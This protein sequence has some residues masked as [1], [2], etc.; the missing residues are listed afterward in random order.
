[1]K[2]LVANAG[3][4]SLKCQFL[5]MPSE[6]QLA[7]AKVERLGT[8]RAVIGSTDRTGQ[9]RE[10]TTPLLCY[11]EAIEFVLGVLT[12]PAKGALSSIS[13]IDA[14]AFKPVYAK[15]ISGCQ[16]MDRRVLDA[17]AEYCD[18]VAPLHNPAYIEAIES[19]A[20]VLPGTPLVGLFEDF[21][22]DNV[23]DYV[24][25]YPIPWEWTEKYGIRKRFFHGASHCY[26]SNRVAELMGQKLDDLNVI[27]AHLGGS[28]S[29]QCIQHGRGIEG[30][31][32]FTLQNGVPQSVRPGEIDPFMIAYLV[33]EGEGTVEEIVDRLM[34]EG[35]LSGISGMGFD[36][37]D[38]QAAAER[39]HE[40]ARLAIDAYVHAIRK[41]I[42][43]WLL[44]LGHTDVITMAGGTGESSPYIRK[45]VLQGCEELGIILD[46]AR[47]EAAVGKES[48][49]SAD[50]SRIQVWVVPTNEEIVVARECYK[51]L[52]LSSQDGS[53]FTSATH[54]IGIG[55]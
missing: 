4:S 54:E 29:I 24:S 51:L 21:Y 20:A 43:S 19:F 34:V 35:G 53:L 23:P 44:V 27:T 45:R 49:I 1:M 8:D 12:E 15:G 26:V 11:R 30:C 18:I 14:V 47:N 9:W 42:G 5:D 31:G 32:G 52:T 22:F 17:M 55:R 16:Y 13:E 7:K 28:S 36:M 6:T 40:R 38:L 46:D 39:G 48:L 2:M 37:R 25:V 50:S 3:S 41:Y 10:T 33:H